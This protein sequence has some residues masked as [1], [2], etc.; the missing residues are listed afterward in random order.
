M[1]TECSVV[2]GDGAPGRAVEILVLTILERPEKR[3]QT[4]ETEPERQ[5]HEN[6]EDFHQDLRT[7]TERARSAFTMTRIEE[8]DIAAAAISGVTIPLIAT[9]TAS[10][11]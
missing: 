5:R 7:A 10:T 11:L 1:K 6:D 9:G 8:P 4:G 3:E 2:I